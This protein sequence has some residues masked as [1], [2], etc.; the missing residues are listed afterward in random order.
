ML[1]EQRPARWWNLLNRASRSALLNGALPWNFYPLVNE[2]PKSGG[3]WLAQM[4]AEALELPNPRRR[5]PM[6]RSS[7]MHGHYL[8]PMNLRNIVMVWR[9]GRDVMVS[10]YYHLVADNNFAGP[11][12]KAHSRRLMGVSDVDDIRA[13]LPR[14]IELV[15][16]GKLHPRFGWGEFHHRWK[17][18]P[19]VLAH[20]RYEAML[21]D[22]GAE[23]FRLQATLGGT[24]SRDVC[25]EIADR[26]SFERQANR[27][28][29]E[30]DNSSFLRKGIAGDW[31][32]HFSP[33][34]ARV[35]DHFSGDALVDLGYEQ[36]RGWVS[37]L[38]GQDG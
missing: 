28:R 34:A 37:R 36:D 19:R 6:L 16:E 33:E 35:F 8:W 30:A 23:L 12:A 31:K 22:A 13:N 21:E 20:T 7:M 4:L 2:Y 14:F 15:S 32:N 5:L 17:D 27:Q 24:R 9:D 10:F 38:E 1:I 18:N 11:T 25:K 26:F 29:G 3:S